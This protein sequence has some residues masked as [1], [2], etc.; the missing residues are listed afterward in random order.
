MRKK[1]EWNQL[2]RNKWKKSL[3]GNDKQ[4]P[5]SKI[6]WKKKFVTS[7]KK[8]AEASNEFFKTKVNNIRKNFPKTNTDPILILEQ[9]SKRSKN[10]I[11][12]PF[13]TLEKTKNII[14]NLTSSNAT[15]HDIISTKIL[16]KIKNQIAPHITHLINTII[17]TSTYPEIYK[18][19]RMLPLCKPGMDPLKLE[20]YRPINNLPCIEKVIEEYF[21]Q[22]M[23]SFFM[24]N[25]TLH[26][27]HHGSRSNHSPTTALTEI[28]SKLNINHDKELHTVALTTD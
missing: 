2:L 10:S 20:S 5:P 12:M 15:G 3:A 13:I 19:S 26:P 27:N 1:K 6:I 4:N 22:C 14:N 7:P 24:E 21:V 23:N 28:I 16:K 18:L 25:N 11:K 9:I 8:I 17:R